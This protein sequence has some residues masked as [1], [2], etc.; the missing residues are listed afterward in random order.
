[1]IEARQ[2]RRR[3]C[4]PGYQLGLLLAGELSLTSLF[5]SDVHFNARVIQQKE[6]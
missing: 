6:E 2:A 4:V 5:H 1:M 3:E